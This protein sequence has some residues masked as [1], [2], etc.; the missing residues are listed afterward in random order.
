MPSFDD[1]TRADQSGRDPAAR[2]RRRLRAGPRLE[3]LET[4][5]L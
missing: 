3:V 5:C 1:R 4:R 2:L